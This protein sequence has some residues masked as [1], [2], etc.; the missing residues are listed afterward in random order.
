MKIGVFPMIAGQ[1]GGGVETYELN[2]VRN[3]AALDQENELRVFCLNNHAAAAFAFDQPN[4][5]YQILWP[6]TRWVSIP[7]TLPLAIKRSC[8]EVVHATFVPPLHCAVPLVVT[9]HDV[10]MPTHQELYPTSIR[11]RFDQLVYKRLRSFD[12]IICPT[13][14]TKTQLLEHY[15]AHEDRITVIPEAVDQ[16]FQ[17]VDGDDLLQI[18]ESYGITQPYLLF[19]GNLRVGNK[20]LIRL[21]E[22]F[23]IFRQRCGSV[24]RLILTG[25]RSWHSNALDEA[26][27]RFGLRKAII[28]TGWVPPDH[29]PALYSGATMLL[30]PTLCEG[31]GLPALEAMACGTPVVTSNI[32]CLPE[33]TG[34]AALLVDPFS[35]ADI[36]EGIIK[37][38]C[39]EGLQV[40]LRERGL[41]WV[42][43][44]SWE[45]T[46]RETL[47][48]YRRA[49][50]S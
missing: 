33:V 38:F 6:R 3:L 9:V 11:W 24:A 15:C 10:C 19:S 34:N 7:L 32:S 35:V 37:L 40:L 22:A 18:L 17:R 5:K 23:S 36:A 45:R 31:F 44:F 1:R 20:N 8:V 2:L 41:E 16:H 47:G 13:E 29:V 46:A 12:Q 50:S 42:K 48:V 49:L 30:F 21:L 43:Q 27:D 14:T 26:I 28:E 25:R 39:D 4:V